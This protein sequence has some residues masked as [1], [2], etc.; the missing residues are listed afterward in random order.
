MDAFFDLQAPGSGRDLQV[1]GE[2]LRTGTGRE[3]LAHARG[4]EFGARHGLGPA[5]AGADQWQLTK[6]CWLS[7]RPAAPDTRSTPFTSR[8]FGTWRLLSGDPAGDDRL[9]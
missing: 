2:I 6:I 9:D 8:V 1:L 4:G 3:A 7:R 5:L